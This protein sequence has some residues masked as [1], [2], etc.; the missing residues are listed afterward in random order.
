MFKFLICLPW[1]VKGTQRFP[2]LEKLDEIFKNHSQDIGKLPRLRR[3]RSLG[4]QREGKQRTV[5]VAFC[6]A[7][8]PV[9]LLVDEHYL[10]H[11]EIEQNRLTCEE[12]SITSG[13]FMGLEEIKTGV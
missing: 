6:A 2:Q 5:S 8:L 13:S 11:R 12:L 3:H 4:S 1:A 10:S 7:F 9:C